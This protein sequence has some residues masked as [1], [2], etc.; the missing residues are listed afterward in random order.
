M[1]QGCQQWITQSTGVWDIFGFDTYWYLFE[2]SDFD[3]LDIFWDIDT[4]DICWDILLFVICI[5]Y[6]F[7]IHTVF[8]CE[9][10][11]W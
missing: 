6:M 3:T 7:T 10:N 9:E 4:L 1:T 8:F 11:I 2:H 5:M